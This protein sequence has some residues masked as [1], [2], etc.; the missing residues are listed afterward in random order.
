MVVYDTVRNLTVLPLQDMKNEFMMVIK[1]KNLNLE[2]E[3]TTTRKNPDL[4]LEI[5]LT[6]IEVV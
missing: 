5:Y 4:N 3:D 2:N 1:Q 6:T